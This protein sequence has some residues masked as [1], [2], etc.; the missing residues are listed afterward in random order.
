MLRMLLALVV[1][2]LA[3]AAWGQDPAKDHL[4]QIIVLQ[5]M[6]AK[7]KASFTAHPKSAKALSAYT[8]STNALA[9]ATMTADGLIPSVKYPKALALYRETLKADPKN[10]TAR[11]NADMIISIYKSMHKPVPGGG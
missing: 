8:Q 5:K 7:A 6:Q 3:M 4:R 9:Y 1:A 2:S 11:K 10:E